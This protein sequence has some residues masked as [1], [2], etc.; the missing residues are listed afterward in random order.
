M[1]PE[2][3]INTLLELLPMAKKP[4]WCKLTGQSMEPLLCHE[5]LLLVQP[6]NR[7][8]RI[9]DIIIFKSHQNQCAHRVVGKT[10]ALGQRLYLTKGDNSYH[11][12]RPVPS[13]QVLG[14]VISAKGDYGTLHLDSVSWRFLNFFIAIYSYMEGKRHKTGSTFWR[15]I[16]RCFSWC[17]NLVGLRH[18]H[19]P[20]LYRRMAAK[21]FDSAP[22]SGGKGENNN[23]ND[24]IR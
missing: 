3:Y 17:H 14:K 4:V 21:K 22:T 2:A 9:G 7:D 6:G 20:D 18:F 23:G 13:E 15:V 12:D 16:D 10:S 5:D 1:I 8:I 11:F 24:E 19:R